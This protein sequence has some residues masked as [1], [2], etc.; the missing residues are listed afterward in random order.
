MREVLMKCLLIA[1]LRDRRTALLLAASTHL[2]GKVVL[3]ALHRN[4]LH[5]RVLQRG[6]AVAVQTLVRLVGHPLLVHFQRADVL[7]V[8]REQ[9]LV[10]DVDRRIGGVEHDRQPEHGAVREVHL[11]DHGLVFGLA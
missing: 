1:D 2:A 7:A 10:A 4:H 3:A 5:C 6:G 8:V 11:L 9:H